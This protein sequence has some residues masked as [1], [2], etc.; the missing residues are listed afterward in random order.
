MQK[1][2]PAVARPAEPSSLDDLLVRTGAGDQSA[3]RTLYDRTS[4]RLFAICL[5]IARDR[6]LAEDILQDVYVRIW[7]RS[8]QFDP[9]RGEA[10]AWITTICRNRTIDVI[11]S[12]GR[13]VPV[14][15]TEFFDIPDADAVRSMEAA[16]DAPPLWRCLGTL[17]DGV[18]RAIVLAYS[19]GL[20]YQ[21]LSTVLG[22]PVGTAKTWVRR[23]MELLRR[24]LDVNDVG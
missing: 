18:R 1:F 9:Q 3:F 8:R 23:G 5:R 24:C 19:N 21:E 7:E 20:T 16:S 12:R 10:M 6:A 17:D 22:I 13:D 2:S 11:R 14:P 15:D 4:A